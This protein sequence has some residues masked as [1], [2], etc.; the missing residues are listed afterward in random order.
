MHPDW[1]DKFIEAL[2]ETGNVSE[3]C[4]QVNVASGVVYGERARNLQFDLD[5][6]D[7]LKPFKYP[8]TPKYWEDDF[9]NELRETGVI[10]KAVRRA[11]I[12]INTVNR[13]RDNNSEFRRKYDE[14]LAA[15]SKKKSRTRRKESL[16]WKQ[17]FLKSLSIYGC[18]VWAADHAGIPP[19]KAYEER[20]RN[21]QFAEDWKFALE[22]AADS[23]QITAHRRAKKSS[24][25]LLKFLL[26]AHRPQLF[27]EHY[28]P[29]EFNYTP[30]ELDE[31]SDEEFDELYYRRYGRFGLK[32][33]DAEETET[34]ENTA[35]ADTLA[36]PAG[37][38]EAGA[39]QRS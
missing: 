27:K 9:L 35:E 36:A 37:A 6:Q 23:L 20:R 28:D 13:R 31:L 33:V 24:D 26:T 10:T 3:A 11:R 34:G 4:R 30:E 1:K 2:R 29:Y 7:A 38:A 17:A 8:S 19:N 5:W 16:L 25:G 15:G 14:A 21:K 39:E 32:D 18:V 22:R 12:S